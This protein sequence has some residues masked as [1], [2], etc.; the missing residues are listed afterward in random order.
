MK[1]SLM[2]LVGLVA[3][4]IAAPPGGWTGF[5]GCD[6]GQ[7]TASGLVDGCEYSAL[8]PTPV[9]YISPTEHER[10]HGD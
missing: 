1:F 3:G 4:A 6:L 9:L 10:R 8:F 2:P 7:A 5:R